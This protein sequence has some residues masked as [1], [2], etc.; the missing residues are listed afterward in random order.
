MNKIK[1]I[2]KI[3]VE[4]ISIWDGG[5]EISSE[6]NLYL[7]NYEIKNI[8][9]STDDSSEVELLDIE[10]VRFK[11][12]NDFLEIKVLYNDNSE[13][14]ELDKN[15]DDFK[16]FEILLNHEKLSQKIEKTISENNNENIRKI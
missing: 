12:K 15:D 2:D 6:A 3:K 14:Y 8:K 13:E 5:Y 9:D 16:K 10:I 11:F 4:F 1:T 7:D